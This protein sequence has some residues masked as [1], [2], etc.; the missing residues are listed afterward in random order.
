MLQH[1]DDRSYTSPV[2]GLQA[3]KYGNAYYHPRLECIE[4]KWPAFIPDDFVIP[5]SVGERL[6][7][8]HKQLLFEN[9]GIVL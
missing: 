8:S 5:A 7:H 9:F 2:S 3:T 4:R 1:Q 6:Q